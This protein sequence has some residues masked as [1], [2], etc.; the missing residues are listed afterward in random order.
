MEPYVYIENDRVVERPTSTTPGQNSPRGVFW[1]P[2]PIAPSLKIEEV[3]PTLQRRATD[4]IRRQTRQQPFFLYLPLTSPHTPWVPTGQWRGKTKAGDYGDFVAQTDHVVGS[5]LKSL[6]DAGLAE[7]TLVIMASDNGAHWTPE[8][9]E[10]YTH[11]ANAS[12]RGMKAD[13]YEAGHRIPFIVRW[14]GKVKP[15]SVSAQLGCLTDFFATAAGIVGMR[16]PRD[17]A[18]D[19]Y[20]LLPALMG[21][22]AARQSVVHHSN[23][24]MFA[25]RDT[26]WKLVLG[27]GSGGFSKPS[28]LDPQPDGPS[29]QLFDLEN[30]PSEA[31]DLFQKRPDV[32]A[33]LTALLRQYQQQ[34]FSRPQA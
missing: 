28:H 19:S 26:R 13:I 10:K 32:V 23:E 22:R 11:R 20:S 7:N 18:E 34:G 14:P 5:A 31:N 30:D 9:K 15:G 6:D 25:I 33:R 12:W 2:G 8:D 24:G 1:R 4:F 16:L 17:A 3:L 29:G 27:L 21:G